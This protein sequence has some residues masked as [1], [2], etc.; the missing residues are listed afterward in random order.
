MNNTLENDFFTALAPVVDK[1]LE[2]MSYK[3]DT[4][5]SGDS[6]LNRLLK[7]LKE[8]RM[9]ALPIE[10]KTKFDDLGIVA[11]G[12]TYLND[13][14]AEISG[15]L[16]E[17]PEQNREVYATSLITPFNKLLQRREDYRKILFCQTWDEYTPEYCLER[18]YMVAELY[19]GYLD[20]ELIKYRLDLFEL[21]EKSGIPL[22]KERCMKTIAARLGSA[23]LAKRYIEALP[24]RQRRTPQQ[25]PPEFPDK[26]NT[27]K[28]RELINKAVGAGFITVEAGLYKWNGTK[29][30][31]AYFAMK[32]TTYLNLP[33]RET[34]NGAT[35]CLAPFE[36][37]F[38][39]QDLKS[40]VNAGKQR[41]GGVL[42][43]KK[44][45]GV[46]ALFDSIE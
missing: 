20:A 19:G 40:S 4:I 42:S 21:Q 35:I 5:E 10:I 9:D 23:T 2:W 46:D 43:P 38:H 7:G 15:N 16:L 18:L 27:A 31:L 1:C 11:N 32:A 37:L 44:Y 12:T 14:I 45:E 29:V 39:E 28:A 41:K 26:L 34:N 6:S 36:T 33:S 30:L 8:L 25:Q 3:Y 22:R 13:L 24:K 17:L